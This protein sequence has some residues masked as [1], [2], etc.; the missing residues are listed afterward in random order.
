MERIRDSMSPS[1]KV[2]SEGIE[3]RYII[4]LQF[5]QSFLEE[6][7]VLIGCAAERGFTLAALADDYCRSVRLTANSPHITLFLCCFP[8]ELDRN[9]NRRVWAASRKDAVLRSVSEKSPALSDLLW[10]YL[11]ST[12]T[13]N[14]T[15]TVVPL[16]IWL[17]VNLMYNYRT[18]W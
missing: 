13:E 16:L 8:S 10:L 18:S 12:R 5:C 3:S 4:I 17:R 9:R 7:K 2:F 15:S 14:K 6:V 1:G 11:N